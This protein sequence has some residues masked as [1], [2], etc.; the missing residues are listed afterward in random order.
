MP[1][2]VLA[3][4]LL[5]GAAAAGSVRAQAPQFPVYQPPK[6]QTAQ[7]PPKPAAR[8]MIL[9]TV[10]DAS[11][12]RGVS[13]AVVRLHGE[14]VMQTRLTDDRG[15]Y[16]LTDLPAGQFSISVIKA[17]YFDG[18][19]GR[20]RAGGDGT[21]I[22]LLEGQAIGDA[23]ISLWRPAVLSG[24]LV[25]E[26]NEPLVGVRVQALRRQY[27]DGHLRL[28]P[29]GEDVSDDEG[30]YRIFNLLPGAY[31]VAVPSG[32]FTVPADQMRQAGTPTEGLT[33][34]LLGSLISADPL[35]AAFPQTAAGAPRN[36]LTVG[37]QSA[38]VPPGDMDGKQVYPTLY[39]PGTTLVSMSMPIEIATA[40]VRTN[41]TL[42][43]AP[44]STA[45]VS[46]VVAGPEGPVSGQVLRLVPRGERDL[47]LGFETCLTISGAGGHFLF[48]AVPAGEYDLKAPSTLM[49]IEPNGSADNESSVLSG[50]GVSM[51][52]DPQGA[53]ATMTLVGGPRAGDRT[54]WGERAVTVSDQDLDDV[55]VS[56]ETGLRLSARAVFDGHATVPDADALR[57][58]RVTLQPVD[59][60][61]A[62]PRAFVDESGAF[63]MQGVAPGRYV[64]AVDAPAGWTL[65]DARV[66]GRD[67]SASLFDLHDDVDGVTLRFT[68]QPPMLTGA[69]R[70]SRGF[71]APGSFAV[72]FPAD[73]RDAVESGVS[74]RR[75]R[76]TRTG[77]SGVFTFASLP[78]G[79][80]WLA[81]MSDAISEGW[82]SSEFL[83][84]LQKMATR[85]TIRPGAA[86]MQ[87]VKLITTKPRR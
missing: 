59:L 23:A 9:G 65:Q 66:D 13:K 38:L 71:A 73:D 41:L 6:S 42:Q 14:N 7:P 44:V 79:D 10:I 24:V 15:R 80:Y 75:I 64:L 22:A 4:L 67:L 69:V 63:V 49:A 56:L 35:P 78:P 83:Q 37:S 50:G 61:R 55:D 86:Q 30:T 16:Y 70:D 36:A 54:L 17:G 19:Y 31:V 58:I 40:E 48:A 72:I 84:A 81:G 11:T 33:P 60:D 52:T 45:R 18:A 34:E 1:R 85:V 21:P 27:F 3:V 76:G 8:G 62:A 82:Q 77:S 57:H 28:V 68:D 47:G 20:T 74:P 53:V 12:G 43:L 25:D 5:A 2:R 39:Y 87:D 32:S 46:G 26:L 51:A 29:A